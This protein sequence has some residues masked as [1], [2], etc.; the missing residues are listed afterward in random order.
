MQQARARQMQRA[1]AGRCQGDGPAALQGGG[2]ATCSRMAGA[3]EGAVARGAAGITRRQAVGRMLGAGATL[4]LGGGTLAG[5]AGCSR[6]SSSKSVDTLQVAEEAIVT[7]DGFT[8]INDPESIYT[9]ADVATLKTGTQLFSAGRGVAAA[10]LTGEKASPLSTVQLLNLEKGTSFGA[11]DRA[12]SADAGYEIYA[13]QCSDSLLAWVESNYLTGDWKVYAAEIRTTQTSRELRNDDGIYYTSISNE[14]SIGEAVQLDA[15][16]AGWDTP[17]VAVVGS[18]AYW[19][20]QPAQDGDHSKED[21]LLKV[22][23][24]RGA[25]STAYTSH[26][27][28]NGGMQASGDTLTVMPRA[29]TSSGVYYQMTAISAGTGQVVAQQVLPRAFQPL[30]AVY[31][32]GNFAF[33]IAAAYDYGGGIANLGTYYPIGDG[34]WLRLTRQ[35]VTAPGLCQG[36]FF[37]KSGART[38]FVDTARRRYFTINAPGDSA[39]YGDYSV[40]LGQVD[41]LYNYASITKGADGDKHVLLRRIELAPPA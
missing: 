10:L 7:L 24:G 11:L 1:Q 13:V 38:A 25:A 36:W 23:A 22:S 14:Y 2:A 6:G 32:D 41:A 30:N 8:Q 29:D 26:G 28:F 27:R 16:D 33:G 18:N 4:A 35:P 37:S 31:L 12:V 3:G 19:I 20:V 5:A 15:G 39:D 17:L 21:S 9:L 40:V 34:T